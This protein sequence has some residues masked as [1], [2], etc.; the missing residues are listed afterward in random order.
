MVR[1]GDREIAKEKFYA[2]KR[3]IK[4]W[5][6]NV[7]NIV[8]S[9]LVKTKSKSKYLI[10]Y[11]NETIR[12]LVLIMPK[13][14]GYVKS[15]K[16]KEGNNKLMSF[17]IDDEKLLEKY[18]AIWTKIEDLKNIKLNALP[19]YDDKYIKAKIR[20]F[21]DKVY[22]NFRGLDVPEDD[23][24][25]ESFTVISIDSLLVYDK[26]YYLQVYLDNCAYKTNCAVNKQ[27]A[28]YLGENLFED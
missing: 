16:V 6:I 24:E 1:F 27:M 17:R 10:R 14:S 28:D 18:K 2:A 13:M 19:V 15:F 12:P 3:P 21:G 26:K 20:T 22:T 23:K 25:C 4:I 9:K 7:D 11:L 8:I 5:D